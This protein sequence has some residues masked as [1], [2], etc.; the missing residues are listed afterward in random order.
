[1]DNGMMSEAGYRILLVEDED[2]HAQLVHMAFQ[3]ESPVDTLEHVRS[4]KDCLAR[5]ENE[6]FDLLILDYSLPDINGIRLVEELQSRSK[7]IPTIIITA[8]GDENVAVQ[9]MKLGATDY[10]IKSPKMLQSLPSIA[11]K[12]IERYQLERRFEE[13]EAHLR[14]QALLLENVHDAI[15]GTDLENEIIYWNSGA[16]RIFGHTS[17][18]ILG[19]SLADIFPSTQGL[20]WQ[21]HHRNA[22][23]TESNLEWQGITVRHQ[24]IWFSVRSRLIFDP[25]GRSVGVLIVAQDI[26]EQKKFQQQA[27]RERQHTAI[28]NQVLTT[29]TTTIEME[30]ML[31]EIVNILAGGFTCDRAW[32][33]AIS[34]RASDASTS[35]P[36]RVEACSNPALRSL[37]LSRELG[38]G[39]TAELFG[40]LLDSVGKPIALDETAFTAPAWREF[41]QR[42]Q[43]AS[44]LLI[45]IEPRSPSPW[46]LG[47]CRT[48]Q[49]RNWNESEKALLAE[50][51]R[52]VTVAIEKSLLYQRAQKATARE[53]LLNRIMQAISHSLDIDKILQTICEELCE[54]LHADRCH[55]TQAMP[56]TGLIT[57]EY[58]KSGWPQM[59]GKFYTKG[60]F[61]TEVEPLRQ[62]RLLVINDLQAVL[63]DSGLARELEQ[64]EIKSL[65]VA[66]VTNEEQLIGT[67]ALYQCSHHRNWTEDEISLMEAVARQFT[68]VLHNA[69]LYTKSRESEERYRNLFDNANDAIIIADVET[70]AIIDANS[71]AETL[72]GHDR[73]RLLKMYLSD[74]HPKHEQVKYQQIYRTLS[75]TGHAHLRDATVW[76][77][78][79]TLLP[80]ELS[81]RV[82]DVN[83]KAV[84]QIL[85]HDMTEQ[86]KLETQLLHVQRLESIGSLTGG[87]AHDFNNLL[88]GILG[89]AELLTKK[90]D[91]SNE[92][93]YNY[94]HIIEQSATRGAELARRLVAFARGGNIESQLIDLNA[95][96]EDTLKLLLPALGRNIEVLSELDAK[97]SPIQANGTQLQQILMNLFIN[98][99]DAMPDG[100]R[101]TISTENLHISEESLSSSTEVTGP[102]RSGD[103]VILTVTDTG[104]GME[105]ETMDRIFEPFFTTKDIGKGTGLGLAMVYS[106]VKGLKGHIE[107]R[108]APGSGSTFRIYLPASVQTMAET[109]QPHRRSMSGTETI[110]I[111]DDEETLRFMAKD[112][113]EAY[114]YNVLLA[115]DGLEAID[116]YLRK[117]DEIAIVI[118]DMVMPRMGGRELYHRLLEINPEVRVVFASGYCPPEI[119]E[120]VWAEGIMGFVQKP[121]QIEDLAAELRMV[122]DGKQE[123]GVRGR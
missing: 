13:A 55:F 5:I 65:L 90:L 119:V 72:T 102:F 112:L 54:N 67:I 122:L 51:G 82:I 21:Q 15:I 14:F 53:Q 27:D 97:L 96:I 2:T 106:I 50:I 118:L 46:L 3:K 108:S 94:A 40:Q 28:I 69:D 74:L 86:R 30:E 103:Y 48:E 95:I 24:K 42:Y 19:H 17:E 64:F 33:E 49:A 7:E 98:A 34:A 63:N 31:S 10:I 70:G 61:W 84:V 43:I 71:K 101:I 18:A 110:L 116:I 22:L 39:L 100:G 56:T 78:D 91:P 41:L 35:L 60:Q 29:I 23:P 113:L 12:A 89:Y 26:T 66:P 44:L 121:Y 45:V 117:K 111:V 11:H 79:N 73:N 93:L 88:A 123:S 85:L 68:I 83:Q 115:A 32:I 104:T 105:K 16:E 6:Y 25:N 37:D 9:L 4:A 58:C 109:E 76:R 92:K 114:G 75:H 36:G 107:V 99:R 47:L 1:M 52:I 87:I 80:A 8:H 57:H 120:Q 20:D 38:A 59:K 62:G 81:G 77:K